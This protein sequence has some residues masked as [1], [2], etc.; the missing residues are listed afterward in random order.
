MSERTARKNKCLVQLKTEN[1]YGFSE[2]LDRKSV[3]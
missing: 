1:P 3:V 2:N